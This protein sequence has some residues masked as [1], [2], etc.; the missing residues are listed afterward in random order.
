M[1][2]PEPVG[3]Q[4][5]CGGARARGDGHESDERDYAED[6][7][8]GAGPLDAGALA[9]PED[10]ERRQQHAHDE[11]ERVLGH[12]LE[13]AAHDGADEEDGGRNS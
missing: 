13:R 7:Q 6:R 2:S 10:A 9:A 4:A 12:A 3:A 11:L 8:V 1:P 5:A